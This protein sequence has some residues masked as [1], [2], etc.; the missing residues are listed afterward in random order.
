[1]NKVAR[2]DVSQDIGAMSWAAP[3]ERLHRIIYC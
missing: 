3:E 2:P 1:M